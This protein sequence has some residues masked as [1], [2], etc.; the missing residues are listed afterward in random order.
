MLRKQSRDFLGA[1]AC[2]GDSFRIGMDIPI[3]HMQQ[4]SVWNVVD[5]SHSYSPADKQGY[6]FLNTND[7]PRTNIH[8][9]HEKASLFVENANGIFREFNNLDLS[10]FKSLYVR[11]K[12]IGRTFQINEDYNNQSI[13]TLTL[14]VHTQKEENWNKK[15][16]YEY[17]Y[18]GQFIGL[19][20]AGGFFKVKF[21]LLQPNDLTTSL[22]K[23]DLSH[24]SKLLF[25]GTMLRIELYA[26]AWLAQNQWLLLL[27]LMMI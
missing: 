25:I 19:P 12:V 22:D 27:A 5:P 17:E 10:R 9:T 26:L 6:I 8:S 11:F 21:N 24:I 3:D 7:R 18:E 23:H 4:T 16:K 14:R 15:D 20:D 13:P 2:I 1:S